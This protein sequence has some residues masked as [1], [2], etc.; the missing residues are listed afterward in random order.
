MRLLNKNYANK[1]ILKRCNDSILQK[2]TS[3]VMK[4]FVVITILKL[5]YQAIFLFL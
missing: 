2:N 5:V 1:S 3:F 4:D